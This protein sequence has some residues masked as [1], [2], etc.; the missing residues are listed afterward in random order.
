MKL[1]TKASMGAEDFAYFAKEVPGTFTFL[2][3]SKECDGVVYPN[4]NSKFLVDEDILI[5]GVDYFVQMSM[6]LL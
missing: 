1:L 3:T 5:K 4:H 6:N 2:N